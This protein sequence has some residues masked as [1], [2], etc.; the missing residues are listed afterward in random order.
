MVPIEM[1][2]EAVAVYLE[3][4]W[5]WTGHMMRDKRGKCKV[6][7]WCP[8]DGKRRK[9]VYKMGGRHQNERWRRMYSRHGNSAHDIRNLFA[10]PGGSECDN[11]DSDPVSE[12]ASETLRRYVRSE[13]VWSSTARDRRGA[14]VEII[15]GAKLQSHEERRPRTSHRRGRPSYLS[16]VP[17]VHR[18]G[19][20]RTHHGLGLFMPVLGVTGSAAA[21]AA[22]ASL[23]SM[24]LRLRAGTPPHSA[25]SRLMSAE[26][27]SYYSTTN[28]VR[29]GPHVDPVF[30]AH[31]KGNS[32]KITSRR[33]HRDYENQLKRYA[34]SGSND[35]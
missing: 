16:R 9:T 20:A 1:G 26:G 8:R 32:A 29:K 7:E 2:R 13:A 35:C 12:E 25:I 24:I 5:R 31:D 34:L 19:C 18:R 23:A 3:K 4:K 22:A 21:G 28:K 17:G 30:S 10:L 27:R 33:D 6:S 11:R 15:R 14:D